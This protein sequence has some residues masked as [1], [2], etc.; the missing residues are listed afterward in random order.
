MSANP[1]DTFE[2]SWVSNV[3]A[4]KMTRSLEVLERLYRDPDRDVEDCQA[5]A[6]A[7]GVI[8]VQRDESRRNVARRCEAWFSADAFRRCTCCVLPH[9]E[10]CG[11]LLGITKSGER[12]YAE[13]AS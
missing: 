12:V 1:Y 10:D 5:L 7:A 4:L 2:C 9:A 13:D 11:L 3:L 8:E 6:Y